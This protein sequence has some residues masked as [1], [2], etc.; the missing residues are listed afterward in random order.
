MLAIALGSIGA[1]RAVTAQSYIP[2]ADAKPNLEVRRQDVLPV[3]WRG[4]S[5]A[6]IERID[7]F[8]AALSLSRSPA[9]V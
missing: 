2:Y 1:A 9:D 8:V 6:E 7:D 4:K 5:V 3:E